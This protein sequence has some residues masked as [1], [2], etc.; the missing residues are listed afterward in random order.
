MAKW[1]PKID[2]L[3]L[4]SVKSQSKKILDLIEVHPSELL[5][6]PLYTELLWPRKVLKLYRSNL[7]IKSKIIYYY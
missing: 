7:F 3:W 5:S 2:D 4:F 1:K 6:A